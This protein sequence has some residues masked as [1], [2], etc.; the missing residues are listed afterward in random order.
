MRDRRRSVR[1]STLIGLYVMYCICVVLR[2][3]KPMSK[4]SRTFNFG[5]TRKLTAVNIDSH[6]ESKSKQTTFFANFFVFTSVPEPRSV[7]TPPFFG[8]IHT[9]DNMYRNN[10]QGRQYRKSYRNSVQKLDFV[11]MA[12][13]SEI[14]EFESRLRQSDK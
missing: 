1:C 14:N 9:F 3:I 5:Y 4:Y 11:V 8:H 10:V 13:K 6:T 12:T 7:Q 2:K